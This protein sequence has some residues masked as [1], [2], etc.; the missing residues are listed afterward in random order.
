MVNGSWR[1]EGE[2]RRRDARMQSIDGI[3]DVRGGKRQNR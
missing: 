1:G 2:V 3:S